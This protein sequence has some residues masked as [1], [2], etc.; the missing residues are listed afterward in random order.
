[1][2]KFI[3][4]LGIYLYL[5]A[6]N[7]IML[8]LSG[9]RD[10]MKKTKTKPIGL[11]TTIRNITCIDYNEI[12][13]SRNILKPFID[14]SIP[15]IIKNFP[16]NMYQEELFENVTS[17]VK[18]KDKV[19]IN[20]TLL[21]K[22]G[23]VGNFI[24]KY[25]NKYVLYMLIFGGGYSGSQAHID[26]FATYNFYYL[27]K[28]EKDVYIIP[29]EYTCYLNMTNG[30][31]S[32]FVGEDKPNSENLEWLKNLPEYYHFTLVEG[33]VL[34]FNNGNC[35]HKFTNLKGDE[36]SCSIKLLSFNASSLIYQR[37]MFN[38]ELAG[39]FADLCLTN[40]SFERPTNLN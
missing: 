17:N 40:G 35:I 16:K 38:W 27:K 5:S 19:L 28:G 34:I 15:I 4:Q 21:P 23:N 10:S 8:I 12:L 37:D 1:M 14:S 32:V 33:D 36:L 29:H 25:I 11:E 31:E 2:I 13:K 6:F 7:L 20:K 3:L 24:H 30:K 22:L 18:N 9:K 26:T 39:I